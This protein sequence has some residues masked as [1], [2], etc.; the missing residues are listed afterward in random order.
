MGSFSIAF[1]TIVVGA[2][3]LPWIFLVIH[4]FFP[5]NESRISSLVDWVNKQNQPA[6]AGLLLFAMAYPLGSVVSRIAQDCFDDDD[7]YAQAMGRVFRVGVTMTQTSILTHVYCQEKEQGLI[8]QT[9][10]DSLSNRPGQYETNDS[11]CLYKGHWLIPQTHQRLSRSEGLAGDIFHVQEGA[12]LLQ[13]T[14]KNERLRQYHDER[15]VLRGAAF[16]GLVA[17]S[18]CLFWWNAERKSKLRYALPFVYLLPGLVALH[19]HLLIERAASNPPLLEFTLLVLSLAGWYL[20]WQSRS[21]GKGGQG[22][23]PAVNGRGHIRP[24]YLLLALFLTVTAFLGWQATEAL[25]DQQV[26]YSS[27]R[28]VSEIRDKPATPS[29][30]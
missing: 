22:A 27:Y 15:M 12:L 8:S 13:G 16:D 21:K 6:V 28:V 30:K 3:A 1:D 9:L 5:E 29:L 25:Y 7:L 2:L 17:F 19:N 24:A 4:L 20:L 10:I 14:D 11:P 18:L 26:I 23:S